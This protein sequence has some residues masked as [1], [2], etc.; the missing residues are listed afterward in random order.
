M[1]SDA[2]CASGTCTVH[3]TNINKARTVRERLCAFMGLNLNLCLGRDA[4]TRNLK[5]SKGRE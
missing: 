1:V 4:N 5:Q 3:A 2:A